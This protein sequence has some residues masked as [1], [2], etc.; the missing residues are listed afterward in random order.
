MLQERSIN[1]SNAKKTRKKKT[2]NRLNKN[3]RT[4][5][6]KDKKK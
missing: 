2:P 4:Q 1:I 5:I 3:R 6:R